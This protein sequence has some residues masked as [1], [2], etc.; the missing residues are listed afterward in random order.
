MIPGM[1]IKKSVL[2][3]LVSVLALALILSILDIDQ[4]ISSVSHM[5]IWLFSIA[6]SLA[7][8]VLFLKT[9]RWHLLLNTKCSVP[10]RET[11][12]SYLAG[13]TMG[14]I[15]PARSGELLRVLYLPV[16][17][18]FRLTGIVVCDKLFDMLSLML[19]SSAGCYMIIGA[20][21][22]LLVIAAFVCGIIFMLYAETLAAYFRSFRL[23]HAIMEFFHMIGHIGLKPREILIYMPLAIVTHMIVLVQCYFL[24]SAFYPVTPEAIMFTFPIIIF[25]NIVPF[26]IGGLGVREGVSVLLL[27][28]FGVPATAAFTAAFLIQFINTFLPGI[29]GA[30]LIT[31]IKTA[32][33]STEVENVRREV[34]IN[35][36]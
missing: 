1:D 17:G 27:P 35:D 12:T 2:A 30:L 20:P 21:V 15:T 32:P 16:S 3:L 14:L 11:F 36:H 10:F 8:V 28:M 19:L 31:R 18:K 22:A 33:T 25:S 6:L 7:P 13:I 23:P 26:T 34:T 29:F 24:V 9:L 4:L 5:D